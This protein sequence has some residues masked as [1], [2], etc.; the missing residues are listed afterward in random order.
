M[1]Q[2]GCGSQ[3]PDLLHVVFKESGLKPISQ[4]TATLSPEVYVLLT[5]VSMCPCITNGSKHIAKKQN[6]NEHKTVSHAE[7]E[8]NLEIVSLC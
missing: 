4:L 8:R 3:N 7:I 5:T 1:M 6:K 2:V